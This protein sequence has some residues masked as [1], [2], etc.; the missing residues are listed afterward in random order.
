MMV[1]YPHYDET[2]TIDMKNPNQSHI[3][4][5]WMMTTDGKSMAQFNVLKDKARLF[6]GVVLQSHMK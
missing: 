2:K 4:L 1:K 5:G 6:A 3:A